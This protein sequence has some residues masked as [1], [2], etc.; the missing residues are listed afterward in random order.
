MQQLTHTEENYIKVVYKLSNNGQQPV[1]TKTLA[2]ELGISPAAITDMIQRLHKKGLLSYQ[3]YQGV[4]ISALGKEHV[5]QVL[6]RRRLWEVFLV[7]KLN[8]AWNQIQDMV[9]EIEHIQ[10]HNLIQA[11]DKYLAYPTHSPHG[12]PIPNI[13]GEMK[14]EIQITLSQFTIGQKGTLLAVKDDSAAFLQYLNKRSIYLGVTIEVL[15]KISFDQSIDVCI[16]GEKFMNIPLKASYNLL[17][18]SS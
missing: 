18:A 12:E 11:L 7:K 15:D 10:S 3:K 5:M 6:R 1:S 8:L 13:C 2:E 9:E 14:T 4:N 17:M 16:D